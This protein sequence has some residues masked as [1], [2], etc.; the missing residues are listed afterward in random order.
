MRTTTSYQNGFTDLTQNTATTNATRGL[1]LVNEAIRYLVGKFYFNERS[2]TTSTV[3]QTQFYNM[4]PQVKNLINVTVSI[5]GVLWVPKFAPTREFWDSLNVITFY[6]DFPSF[7]YVYNG[8][9]GNPQMG[10]FPIPASSS[11]TITMNYKIRT[12]DLSQADYTTGTVAVTN[13]SPT[14]TGTG[15]TFVANMVNRWIRVTAPDGDEQWYQIKTFT[16][17]TSLTLY[18]NYTGNTASGAAYT[19]G[20]API[21]PED[22]QDLPLY[23]ALYIYY[24][25]IVPDKGRAELWKNL[26]EEGYAMLQSEYGEKTTN[27]A[28]TDTDAPVYNPNLFVRSISQI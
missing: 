9:A 13:G 20:E 16:S 24:N 7:F 23:R 4:P 27:V 28:L 1:L 26:Y 14:I 17:T 22:Y 18:N 25:S 11:N 5:G 21:L 10:L 2:Y 8:T 15:T 19:I 6:Q 12:I 3:A